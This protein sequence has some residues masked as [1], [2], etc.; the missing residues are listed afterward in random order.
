MWYK[1]G[2]CLGPIVW[3]HTK[4][5]PYD[6]L[7]IQSCFSPTQFCCFYWLIYQWSS[8][9]FYLNCCIV[10]KCI[11]LLLCKVVFGQRASCQYFC[12]NDCA[13]L[14]NLPCHWCYSF[15]QNHFWPL[16]VYSKGY[17]TFCYPAFHYPDHFATPAK[18]YFWLIWFFY[19]LFWFK[20][21]L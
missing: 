11:R 3:C 5:L 8:T 10:L 9:I 17:R 4:T 13:F 19:I 6:G 20:G 14:S 12:K 16:C 7:Q 1:K 21:R 2:H 15:G 18:F